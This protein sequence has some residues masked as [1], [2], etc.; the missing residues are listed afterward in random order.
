M[1]SRGFLGAGDLYIRRYNPNTAEFE[2]WTGPYEATKFEIKPNTE[3]KELSSRG[4]SSYGQ[5]IESVALAQPADFA[6]ALPE[7]N[8]ETMTLAL[9]GAQAVINEGSGTVEDEAVTAVHDKWLE[10]DHR[11]LQAAGLSVKNSAESTTYVLGTDYEINYRL[12][13][14][15]V[16]SDGAITN[17]Q[18]IKVNYT[19]SAVSGTRIRGAVNAE[20]RM[21]LKL[22]GKN[23]ADGLPCIV[24]VHEAVI[25]ADSAFD[26]LS[27]DFATVELPGRLKTPVGKTEPFEVELLDTEIGND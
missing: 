25:A 20:L 13:M 9:L 11:N 5:V 10:L 7:V 14:I 1:S 15:R 27:S 4:R 19:H 6:I 16:L 26:F 12:G 17:G 21:Q 24:T 2:D 3:L 8:R 23:Q 22:D 18:S